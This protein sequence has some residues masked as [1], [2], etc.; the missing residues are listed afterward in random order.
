M[1]F[2]Y[3][4]SVD[5]RCSSSVVKQSENKIILKIFKQNL[6]GLKD[7]RITII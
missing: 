1:F 5:H 2:S 3:R 6:A 4:S 7:A